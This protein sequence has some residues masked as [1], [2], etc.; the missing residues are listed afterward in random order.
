MDI[1]NI[2]MAVLVFGVM[3]CVYI[4]L[5]LMNKKTPKPEGCENLRADCE[6][7]KDFGCAN[8]PSHHES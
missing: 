6:G 4:F 5:Y 8:H 2:L 7:C 1:G 3:V